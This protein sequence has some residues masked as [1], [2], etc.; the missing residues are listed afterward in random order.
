MCNGCYVDMTPDPSRDTTGLVDGS[1]N[2][3]VIFPDVGA[4]KLPFTR[5]SQ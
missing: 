4:Q 1:G 3:F 2:S 5:Q